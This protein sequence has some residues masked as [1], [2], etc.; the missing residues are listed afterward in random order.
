VPS[1]AWQRRPGWR[2]APRAAFVGRLAPEKGLDTL[3]DAW[4]SVVVAFPGARLVLIGEGPER[5]SLEDR[6]RSLGLGPFVELPGIAADPTA[7]LREADLFILPSREEGMSIALLEAMALGI[8]V[9]AS[10][11][12]GNRRIVADFKHGLLAPVDDPA[13]LAIVIIEQWSYFDRA[14]HMSRA[15][16]SRVEQ[17]F[18]IRSVA[19]THL[20]LFSELIG[21]AGA[22]RPTVEG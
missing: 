4:G 3:I 2:V 21:D 11:I 22:H 16:R 7:A 10:S 12:P 8:P 14:F 20:A 19:R 17:E 1:V 6:V 13:G 5:R 15:A 18:S 9:V